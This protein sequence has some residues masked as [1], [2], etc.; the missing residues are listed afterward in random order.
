[1][2]QHCYLLHTERLS[3]GDWILKKVLDVEIRES[4][5]SNTGIEMIETKRSGLEGDSVYF[6]NAKGEVFSFNKLNTE[7]KI[8]DV[9]IRSTE[10]F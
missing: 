6:M 3:L 2:E 8:Y 4:F 7:S 1:M 9:I 5:V 10:I